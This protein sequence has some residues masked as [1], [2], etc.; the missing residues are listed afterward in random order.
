MAKTRIINA[1]FANFIFCFSVFKC[2]FMGSYNVPAENVTLPIQNGF[3]RIFINS[4]DIHCYWKHCD[5]RLVLWNCSVTCL[6][7]YISI[8]LPFY[9]G[10]ADTL[11]HCKEKLS[12]AIGNIFHKHLDF[13]YSWCAAGV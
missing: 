13:T 5:F 6:Y 4:M 10:P 3:R 7:V 9:T 2:Q 1:V 11:R 8:F 12:I